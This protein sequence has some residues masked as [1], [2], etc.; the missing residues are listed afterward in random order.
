LEEEMST[1]FVNQVLSETV[2]SVIVEVEAANVGNVANGS[3]VQ[4]VLSADE[5]KG[6]HCKC[7]VEIDAE[8]VEPLRGKE[9]VYTV[10]KANE[11]VSC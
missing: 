2:A 9:S 3:V 8:G 10:A 7:T 1:D 5:K 6:F 11:H 4:S